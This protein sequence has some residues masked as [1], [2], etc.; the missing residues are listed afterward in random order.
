[1]LKKGSIGLSDSELMSPDNLNANFA[2]FAFAPL[3][4]KACYLKLNGSERLSTP[5]P[6]SKRTV[7][8]SSIKLNPQASRSESNHKSGLPVYQAESAGQSNRILSELGQVIYSGSIPK[9]VTRL[10][11]TST[12]AHAEGWSQ[13]C[14]MRSSHPRACSITCR[15]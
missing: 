13:R 10:S 7:R 12:M 14:T 1:L 8:I 4:A 11:A 2:Q 6:R 15:S 9:S 3:K 5:S